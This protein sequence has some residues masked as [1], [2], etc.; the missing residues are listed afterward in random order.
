MGQAIATPCSQPVSTLC[1]VSLLVDLFL[2]SSD[3]CILLFKAIVNPLFRKKNRTYLQTS[4]CAP[5]GQNGVD[6]DLCA[7]IQIGSG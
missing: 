1:E 4:V 5:K 2:F 3:R 6:P 7:P